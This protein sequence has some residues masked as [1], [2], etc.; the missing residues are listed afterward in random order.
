MSG[1]GDL[2]AIND[3]NRRKIVGRAYL[4]SD[5]D[6]MIDH[7]VVMDEGITEAAFGEIVRRW[8]LAVADFKKVIGW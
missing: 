2:E 1:G 4:D 3:W 7:V 8:G 5:N 6:P